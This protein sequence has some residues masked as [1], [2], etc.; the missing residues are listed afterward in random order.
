MIPT[1]LSRASGEVVVGDGWEMVAVITVGISGL[2]GR[3][4]VTTVSPRNAD[5]LISTG[6]VPVD[7]LHAGIKVG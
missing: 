2:E 5:I 3:A 4:R 7:G 1:D 6:G